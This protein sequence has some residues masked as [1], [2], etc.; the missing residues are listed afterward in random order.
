MAFW[1]VNHKQTRDH[2]VRGGYLWSPMRNSNGARNQTY[3]N[4]RL[5]RL[6]D[7]V[8]SYAHS[9]IG[10]I[11]RVTEPATSCP[12]PD[13]FGDVG[14]YWSNEGWMVEVDFRP[15]PRPLQPS[16]AIDTI[17]PLL[18]TR[19]S[20]I[21]K[22]GHG[23]QGCYLAGISDALGQLLLALMSADRVADGD[24]AADVAPVDSTRPDVLEDIHRIEADVSL[25]VTQRLQLAKARVGQGL[26]RKRVIVLD[27]VC[28]VTGVTDTRVLVASHIKPWREADNADRLDGNNGILLSPHVDALFDEELLSFEDDGQML[29]HPS[30]SPDVL[31]RWSIDSAKRVEP[32]RDQQRRFLAR[33]RELFAQRAR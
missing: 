23:N 21:Q 22:N 27:G 24:I 2:E 17:G 29:V 6:G 16:Q 9:R 26:F 31:Y 20:P 1:W 10:A 18:P 32:F 8:F 33:H 4:M 19:Y 3:E 11:G 14:G 30:L 7:T 12:K 13:E 25:T 28:R 15:V 5:V